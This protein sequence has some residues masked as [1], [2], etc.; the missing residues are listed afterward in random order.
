MSY[1]RPKITNVLADGNHRSPRLVNLLIVAAWIAAAVI[2]NLVLTLTPVKPSGTSSALLPHDATT[3]AVTSRIAQAFPGAGTDAI[4]YLVVEG[5][6]PLE[7]EEQPYYDAAISALRAD[8]RHVGSVLDWWSDPLTAPLGTSPDGRA[9]IGMMWLRGEAGTAQASESLDAVRSVVRQLPPSEGLR[10]RIVVPATTNAMPMEM[11]AW[12]GAAIV[13]AAAVIAVLLLRRAR[14]SVRAA[15]IVLLTADLSLAVAWP[16][17]AVV[18]GQAGGTVSGFSWTLA[19]AL[20]L[21]TIT[22]ST[23]LVLRSNADASV[24]PTYRD[25]LPALALA[26]V[27]LLT[28]PL[29]LARTPALHSVGIA[30][31]GVVVALAASLTLLPNLIELAGPSGPAR[32]LAGGDAWT[33]RSSIPSFSSPARI[34]AMVLAICALLVIGM[35][36][37]L[38]EHQAG[39]GGAQILPGN[40]LPDVVLIRST[41]DLRDPAA[42]IAIDQVSHRL[43]EI[44]GVRKVESAAWPAGVPW[45]DAALTSAAGRLADQLGQQAGSF[46]PAVTA[47]KQ[48]KAMIDQMSGAVDQLETTVNVAVAGAQQAQQFLNPMLSAARSLKNRAAD[49]SGYL[50]TIRSWII[51]VTNCPADALCS[52]M[53][54]VIEPYDQ[55]AAGMDQLSNGV[56]RISAISTQTMGTLSA[57][58][59]MVAQMRS[60]LGQVRAFIPRL[61]TTIQELMPQIAQ[62]SAMLKNLSADFADTGEGGFHLTMKELM[63]PSYQHVRESMFSSDG[64]ATRLFV[65]SDGHNLDLDAA[66]RAQQLE[67]A[68]GKAM[69]YGSLVGSQ[70][71]VGGAAQVAVAARAAFIHDA[72]L[73]AVTLLAVV[74]LVSIWGGAARGAAVGL[75]MLAAYLG[76]LGISVALWQHLLDRELQAAVPLVSFAVLASCGVPYL[77]A[78][79]VSVRRA[80]TPLTALGAALGA[81][82][83]LVSGGF[84]S[85]LSQVGTVLVLGLGALTAVQR[86]WLPPRQS[87][88]DAG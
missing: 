73:L 83:V 80:I 25:R 34:T 48:M 54:K 11:A 74:C 4:A 35:R 29:L 64:T 43:M 15:G 60:A 28:G 2:A 63:S 24:A 7:P 72:V 86:T 27:A 31:L 53:R 1:V 71:T 3:A 45:A 42:L 46:V 44:P 23:M 17:A 65:Y 40:P 37:G 10:A 81:G 55:V 58:P 6:N 8:T 5:S 32:P 26:C 12:Q 38:T 16:L 30:A 61:E 79:T 36:L 20:T 88:R 41:R 39:Q 13:A 22:A 14:R 70:I 69:K 82:L 87:G 78:A 19:A 62:A 57:A 33:R 85:T 50:D 68:A 51:N 9:A 59:R 49:V 77:I 18:R 21:G 67:I 75:G 76:A 84:V 47:I 52:A 56:D 66:A